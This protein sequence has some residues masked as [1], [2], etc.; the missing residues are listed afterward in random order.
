MSG[1]IIRPERESDWRAA[2]E[3][4]REAFWNLYAPG[5]N[6]HYL[7]HLLRDSGA[8]IGALDWVAEK[9]GEVVGSIVFSHSMILGDDGQAHPAITFGP[10]SVL[11]ALQGTGIGSLLIRRTLEE[12]RK[13]GHQAVLIYG[14]PGYYAR[15]GFAGAER[16]DIRS[17]D[18]YYA[19]ALLALELAPG[20]L[21]GKA[22][23]F[24]EDALFDVDEAAAEAFDRGF[25]LKEKLA[26]LPSQE[27]F[28]E[29]VRRR[30][31]K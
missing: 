11:P 5:C 22:G 1:H 26:G 10:V 29:I 13:L 31:A 6:E 9:N 24:T 12:A 20:A 14:D 18:D 27:R 3:V 25:P 21:E 4:T 17:Q 8:F 7:L 2:E 19:D 15:F 23:R 30:R 28:L 16:F